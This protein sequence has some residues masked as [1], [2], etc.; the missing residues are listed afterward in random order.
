MSLVPIGAVGSGNDQA[1]RRHVEDQ[2]LWSKGAAF[3]ITPYRIAWRGGHV[4]ALIY[5]TVFREH[6]Y[7]DKGL[8]RAARAAVVYL[9]GGELV[10]FGSSL[11]AME[12]QTWRESRL[13]VLPEHRGIGLG[14][15]LSEW[16]GEH[17]LSRGDRFRSVTQNEQVGAARD[18][19]PRWEASTWNKRVRSPGTK[20]SENHRTAV[21]LFSHE[22]VGEAP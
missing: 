17:H 20:N 3:P 18:K 13:V 7:L 19:S 15:A 5:D 9:P 10:A 16:F 22:Y 1:S 2:P 6:H 11:H 8:P 14:R 21:L 12:V 4:A